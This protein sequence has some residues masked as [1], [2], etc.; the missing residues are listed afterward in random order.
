M[1]IRRR[2]RKK[3]PKDFVTPV[4]SLGAELYCPRS[5]ISPFPLQTREQILWALNWWARP[6]APFFSCLSLERKHLPPPILVVTQGLFNPT[7]VTFS[8]F[9]PSQKATSKSKLIFFHRCVIP[10]SSG[11]LVEV[12]LTGIFLQESEMM[13]ETIKQLLIS[14]SDWGGLCTVV[15]SLSRGPSLIVLINTPHGHHRC[16]T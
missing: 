14:L 10:G 8:S 6:P 13:G 15:K 5:L 9:T 11:C 1:H 12:D 2:G 16:S 4:R 3:N 7:S